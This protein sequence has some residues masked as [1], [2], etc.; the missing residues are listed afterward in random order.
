LHLGG[1]KKCGE[2]EEKSRRA[3]RRQKVASVRRATGLGS[4]H[5]Y[6]I[7]R[8]KESKSPDEHLKGQSVKKSRR[9]SRRQKVASVR[10]A[11]G[12]GSPHHYNITRVK[13]S[14]NP[15]GRQDVKKSHLCVGRPASGILTSSSLPRR[16][17]HAADATPVALY[18]ET[19]FQGHALTKWLLGVMFFILPLGLNWGRL[20]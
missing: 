17:V 3:S 6:N 13:E 14:K 4:P 18:V 19:C 12:L 2:L 7:T 16:R 11:T 8:V 15:V 5:H 9:A 20:A 1:D 10:R